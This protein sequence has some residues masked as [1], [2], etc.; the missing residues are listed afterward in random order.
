MSTVSLY[1]ERPSYKSDMPQAR[2]L[3]YTK[4]IVLTFFL[5]TNQNHFNN[6]G[7]GPG[8]IYVEFGQISI[9]DSREEVV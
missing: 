9:S 3:F 2:A 8:I 4:G 6:F 7:R 5:A 1:I